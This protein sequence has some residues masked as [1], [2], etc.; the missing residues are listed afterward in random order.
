MGRRRMQPGA[1]MGMSMATP[2]CPSPAFGMMTR[3]KMKPLGLPMSDDERAERDRQKAA[4][5]AEAL[6]RAQAKRERKQQR[7][8]A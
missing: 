7:R 4:R 3:R 5:A 6:A 2:A 1:N 8:L